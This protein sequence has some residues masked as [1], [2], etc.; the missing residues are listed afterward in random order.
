MKGNKHEVAVI[1]DLM[2]PDNKKVNKGSHKKNLKTIK[3]KQEM[4]RAKK[5]EKEQYIPRMINLLI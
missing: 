2:Y 1:K 5:E 3:E 4:N